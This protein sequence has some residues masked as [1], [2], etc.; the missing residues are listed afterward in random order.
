VGAGSE[1][2]GSMDLLASATCF[3]EKQPYMNWSWSAM[4]YRRG[5]CTLLDGVLSTSRAAFW[6]RGKV[7]DLKRVCRRASLLIT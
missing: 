3:A 7:N 2:S 4:R 6:V 1:G 5:M